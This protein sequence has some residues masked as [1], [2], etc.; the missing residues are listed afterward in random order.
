MSKAKIE[1]EVFGQIEPALDA[2]A[3]FYRRTGQ[4]WAVLYLRERDHCKKAARPSTGPSCLSTRARS[5][6]NPRPLFG[7][8]P[9]QK[10]MET[11]AAFDD[12]AVASVCPISGRRRPGRHMCGG[13]TKG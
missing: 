12:E 8:A 9:P 7:A 13:P 4:R 11:N 3:R 2:L 10:N 1:R 5:S 6:S